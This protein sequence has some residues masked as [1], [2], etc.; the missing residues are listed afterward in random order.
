MAHSWATNIDFSV[1]ST[2]QDYRFEDNSTGIDSRFYSYDSRE[3]ISELEGDQANNYVLTI[4]KQSSGFTI[5]TGVIHDKR[6]QGRNTH[7]NRF[8]YKK[9]GMSP[10]LLV[11][12]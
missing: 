7:N 1:K 2:S 12:L 11:G 9:G 10:V 6:E 8:K 3:K 5:T 4:T